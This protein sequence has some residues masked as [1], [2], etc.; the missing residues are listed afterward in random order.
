MKVLMLGW[1]FPPHISGGLGTACEGLTVGLAQHQVEVLFVVPEIFGG[2]RA[3]H[4]DLVDS[5]GRSSAGSNGYSAGG[6]EIRAR[7]PS[8]EKIVRKGVPSF[9]AP[10]VSPG[11][12]SQFVAELKTRREQGKLKVEDITDVF[13]LAAETGSQ[14]PTARYDSNIFEEVKKYTSRVAALFSGEDFDV[15]HAHDWMTFPAGVALSQ[16]TG[17]PLI[18]HVHSLEFDRS[19]EHPNKDIAQVERFGLEH[20][21]VVIAVSH[22]TKRVISEHHGIPPERIFVVHNGIYPASAVRSYRLEKPWRSK[23]VLFLGRITFQKGPDYFVEAAAKVVPFVPDVLFVMAGS[24]D[25]K[26]RMVDRVGELGLSENFY[27]P[28]FLKGAE[29]EEMFSVADVYVMPSV[30][31]PFGISALEAIKFDTPVIISRQSGVSEVISH[32]LKVDFWDIER[33]AELII[34]SLIHEELRADMISM[35]REEIRRLHWEASA[36]KTIEIYRSLL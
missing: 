35:A 31:E 8:A 20:A 32:A 11:N 10:Y 5:L 9:L 18:V 21:D 24:G 19:G 17:K 26:Q 14:S 16:L 29:V 34:N 36:M 1:E 13:D 33:L 4:L 25:M 27:F 6:S 28:G 22:Y 15:I 30:S 23:V 7:F 3:Q 12:F 2:E